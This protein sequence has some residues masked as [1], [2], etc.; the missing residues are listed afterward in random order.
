MGPV[1][2][3][4]YVKPYRLDMLRPLRVDGKSLK[5]YWS[6]VGRVVLKKVKQW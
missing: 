1:A 6:R 2:P 5:A 4:A 3:D